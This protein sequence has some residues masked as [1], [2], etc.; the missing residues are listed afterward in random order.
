M[1]VPI[2]EEEQ[3]NVVVHGKH[4]WSD[5]IK[6]STEHFICEEKHVMPQG[7]DEIKNIQMRERTKSS[8]CIVRFTILSCVLTVLKTWIKDE[9]K[10][11]IIDNEYEDG[12][13][14]RH[15][16]KLKKKFPNN[17]KDWIHR[18]VKTFQFLPTPVIYQICM[19]YSQDYNKYIDERT[20][21]NSQMKDS[22][23][24]EWSRLS[25]FANYPMTE[26]SVIRLAGAGFFY[27]GN[28]DEVTC[29]FCGLRHGHWNSKDN[30]KEL[31]RKQSPNCSYVI[32]MNVNDTSLAIHES[33]AIPETIGYGACGNQEDVENMHAMDRNKQ[34][35]ERQNIPAKT[36]GCYSETN[37]TSI[38]RNINQK[39]DEVNL[40]CP[41]PRTETITPARNLTSIPTN[42]TKASPDDT[43][44]QLSFQSRP[45]E[46]F[47]SRNDTTG[48]IRVPRNYSEQ[49]LLET[50][51][52]VSTQS[53]TSHSEATNMGVCI[54]KPKYPKYAIRTTRLT[55]FTNWPSYLTQTPEN[56]A[57]A[58]F[59][60][61]GK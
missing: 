5:G 10:K 48:L 14:P 60:Y 3:G 54:D 58:G 4:I 46:M 20:K 13:K 55:S 6:N 1:A 7:A 40:P 52:T 59:F 39:S 38:S 34:S 18:F 26:V 56:L 37:D 33:L 23:Q 22:M 57:I 30:P 45:T 9:N 32:S 2:V 49:V 44:N 8:S 27:E 47:S 24:F 16:P 25:T 36:N 12:Y 31:H 61:T 28:D 19:L 43:S 41:V 53:S 51:L 50:P 15:R 35:D 29:Y 17:K 21:L 11:I 42:C